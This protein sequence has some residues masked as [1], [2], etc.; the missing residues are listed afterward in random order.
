MPSP[1]E[2]D[3]GL[4]FWPLHPRRRII[5]ESSFLVNHL[6]GSGPLSV[7][8]HTSLEF[9]TVNENILSGKLGSA[10]CKKC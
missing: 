10:A 1:A 5:S 7:D 2:R 9:C 4:A 3:E 6:C 8:V